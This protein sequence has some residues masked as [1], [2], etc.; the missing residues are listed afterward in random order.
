KR[1]VRRLG[2]AIVGDDDLI[3]CSSACCC[4]SLPSQFSNCSSSGT[5]PSA[6]SHLLLRF[7]KAKKPL[8]S[9]L[10]TDPF[11]WPSCRRR[12]GRRS[13]CVAGQRTAAR[14]ASRRKGVGPEY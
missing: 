11:P 14:R 8:V 4:C 6:N 12:S 9:I 7:T 13:R 5:C 10:R 2:D 1:K 3:V